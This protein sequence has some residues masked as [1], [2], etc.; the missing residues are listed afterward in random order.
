MRILSWIL[1]FVLHAC[2][3]LAGVYLATPGNVNVDLDVPVYEVEIVRLQPKKGRPAPVP[4]PAAKAS[5]KKSAPKPAPE[6]APVEPKPKAKAIA[7]KVAKPVKEKPEPKKVAKKAPPKK[8]VKPKKKPKPQKKPAKK[9][10]KSKKQLLAEALKHAQLDV[11]WEERLERKEKDKALD[12]L[13][14]MVAEEDAA[15][16]GEAVAEDGAGGETDDGVMM[17]LKEIYAAQVMQA[18]K[19]N[20]RY[21]SIPV[22]QVLTASVFMRVSQ[23]GHVTEVALI[24]P[25]G[26]V[27]F[28]D[29]VL[30]AIEE[31]EELPPPPGLIREIRINFNLQDM[32]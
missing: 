11:K 7:D 13:R 15:A 17:G 25:S 2:V 16:Q 19:E 27:D 30:K 26:R 28:D 4:K 21:P 6:P 1:S 10:G 8:P 31:T 24:A 14:K 23:T 29:S 9:P 18:V 22:E 12:D 3:A 20:W 5:V 32:R